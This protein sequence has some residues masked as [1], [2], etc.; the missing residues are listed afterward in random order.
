MIGAFSLT[1]IGCGNGTTTPTQDPSST[2]PGPITFT[3]ATKDSGLPAQT[4]FCVVF[5]DLDAD[6]KPDVVVAPPDASGQFTKQVAIYQNSG[7]G[8]FSQTSLPVTNG[9][10]ITGCTTTDYDNDG[11]LD[12]LFLFAAPTS[13]ALYHNKG[14]M[15]FEDVTSLIAKGAVPAMPAITGSASTFDYDNDG[16]LDILVGFY[17]VPVGPLGCPPVDHC[18]GDDNGYEC[19]L[20]APIPGIP[21]VLLHNKAG[22]GFEAA[23]SAPG[24]EDPASV[25]GLGVLDWNGDGYLDVFFAHDWSTNRLYLNQAGTG[26]H[27][28]LGDLKANPYVSGGMGVA[29]A[30]FNK[31]QLWDFYISNLGPDLLYISSPGPVGSAITNGA[32]AMGVTAATRFHSAWDPIAADFDHDGWVDVYLNN[33]LVASDAKDMDRMSTPTSIC[34]PSMPAAPQVDFVLTNQGGKTFKAS[35]VPNNAKAAWPGF[36]MTAAADYD[37]DGDIDVVEFSMVANP[38]FR[39]MRNDTTNKG[40]WLSVHLKPTK[41]KSNGLAYGS[42]ITVNDGT[43]YLDRRAVGAEGGTGKS[44][45]DAHFGLGSKTSV[46]PIHVRWPSGMEQD[47]PAPIKVDQVLTITEP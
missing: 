47:V 1:F 26:W 7:G 18:A 46:G 33:T 36:G 27:N 45:V 4:T 2:P 16:F 21:P 11:K 9:N 20:K 37:G 15:Q 34:M 30:D 3:D 10:V 43:N 39:L 40:H 22:Q 25:N 41:P 35:S 12:L 8:K 6:G 19:I 44:A 17:N 29:F 23:A 13:V 14:G 28:A 31:D 5:Q 24:A 38:S 32:P 42:V